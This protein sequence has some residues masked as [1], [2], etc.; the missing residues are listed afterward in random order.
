MCPRMTSSPSSRSSECEKNA[1]RGID[2]GARKNAM[3]RL[4]HQSLELDSDGIVVE[5]HREWYRDY[6]KRG[7]DPRRRP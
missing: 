4:L 6:S 7:H 3:Q 2:P 5:A 1:R